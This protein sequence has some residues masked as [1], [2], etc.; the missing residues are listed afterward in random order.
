MAKS[1]TA[2][3]QSK[4]E[5]PYPDFPLFPH[6]SGRWAKKIKGSLHYFG[7]WAT[8]E[9]GKLVP[10]ADVAASAQLAVDKY[11]D[12]RDDLYAG[13]KPRKRGDAAGL[14]VKVLCN[15][16]WVEQKN[17]MQA[18]DI[19]ARTF[20]EYYRSTD[21]ITKAFG[22]TRL[23]DDLTGED[24]SALRADLAKNR[25]PVS[26]GNEIQRIRTVFKWAF[27]NA[28]IDKPVRYG[29]MFDKPDATAVRRARGARGEQMFEAAELRTLIDAAD[30][31]VKA[32]IMC[33]I[34]GAFGAEDLSCLPLSAIDL[35]RG[36]ISFPRVKTSIARRVPLWPETVEAVR[37][38]LASRPEPHDEADAGLAFLTARGKRWV[39]HSKSE[40]ARKWTSR[41]DGI[42]HAFARVMKAKGIN[43]GRGFYCLRRTFQTIAEGA[44]D[45]PAVGHVMGHAPRQGDM[46]AVY[47]V[48]IADER[49]RAVTGA[50]R[51]W[52]FAASADEATKGG[53]V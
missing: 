32:L 16:F 27:D 43:G 33:A 19:T 50:V 21:K 52:L 3:R 14:T 45:F 31:P 24:F 44:G 4:P 47:R 25:G 28:L 35:A 8:V 22:L 46:A 37:V 49:L 5:K 11:G 42:S 9:G 6:A 15:A 10:V 48:R 53:A 34:N 41:Q 40:D 13:R 23:V 30:G 1:T 29:T 38:A 18:G 12:E 17:R 20:G 36:W 2:R 26:L 39:Q 7:R 51:T